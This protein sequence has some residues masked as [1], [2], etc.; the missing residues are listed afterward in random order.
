MKKTSKFWPFGDPEVEI[1]DNPSWDLPGWRRAI[2]GRD[3]KAARRPL[4]RPG[5]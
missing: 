3:G 2:N 5:K 1:Y 4:R